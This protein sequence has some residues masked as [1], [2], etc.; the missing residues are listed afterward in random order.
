MVSVVMMM[1]V[2]EDGVAASKA[3][4]GAMRNAMSWCRSRWLRG[5]WAYEVVC[6]DAN[7][8]ARWQVRH[9][10]GKERVA[11]GGRV[12]GHDMHVLMI[13]I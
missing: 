9:V 5:R 4:D 13:K 8:Q 3:E 10:S 1:M 7:G 6:D 2:C 12:G 11:G